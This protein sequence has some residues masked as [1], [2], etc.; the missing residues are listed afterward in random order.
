M[1]NEATTNG[2]PS[3][4]I[5]MR[6]I[7]RQPFLS[8]VREVQQVVYNLSERVVMCFV[9]KTRS[10]TNTHL[11]YYD[12][13]LIEREEPY[14]CFFLMQLDKRL[15]ELSPRFH[16][17]RYLFSTKLTS[18]LA[19]K[20]STFDKPVRSTACSKNAHRL[21][22]DS[23]SVTFQPTNKCNKLELE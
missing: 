7:L 20:T 15:T 17:V 13:A 5:C 21:C 12:R 3:I 1:L 10:N 19:H 9:C 2:R 18:A 16:I 11:F 6:C 8:Q 14:L 4:S 22:M 23:K